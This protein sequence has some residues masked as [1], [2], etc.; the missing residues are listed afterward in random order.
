[1]FGRGGSAVESQATVGA[2]LMLLGR[3]GAEQLVRKFA[4]PDAPLVDAILSLQ[5]LVQDADWIQSVDLNPVLVD[6]T[7]VV[8]LDAKIFTRPSWVS[9]EG[10]PGSG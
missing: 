10:S 3:R 7:G 6:E 2:R 8:A 9:R 5:R 4:I 1:M